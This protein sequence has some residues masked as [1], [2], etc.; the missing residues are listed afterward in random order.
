MLSVKYEQR[1][2]G[3]LSAADRRRRLELGADAVRSALQDHR[4][5]LLIRATDSRGRGDELART[6]VALGCTTVTWGTK[7]SLGDVF[8]RSAVGVLLITDRGI[9]AAVLDC[10]S[11]VEALSEDG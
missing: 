8:S 4:G 3:L 11:H 6:A 9:A 2:L 1:V 10:L 5:D 7:A